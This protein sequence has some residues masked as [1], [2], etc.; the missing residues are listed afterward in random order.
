MPIWKTAASLYRMGWCISTVR[1]SKIRSNNRKTFK[2]L[3]AT[4]NQVHQG[5]TIYRYLLTFLVSLAPKRPRSLVI[6][7]AKILVF[8]LTNYSV[9]QQKAE[10]IE[11]LALK[12][13]PKKR[14]QISCR[15]WVM[16]WKRVK[17][18]QKRPSI[19]LFALSSWK[20]RS[21]QMQIPARNRWWI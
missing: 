2:A 5:R 11:I 12:K 16:K 17:E 6:W 10:S 1:T 20:G 21:V 8:R 9:N 7:Q 18:Y 3:Q 19:Y 13:V 14:A 15:S 4:H